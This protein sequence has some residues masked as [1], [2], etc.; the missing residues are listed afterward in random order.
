MLMK[1]PTGW[2]HNYAMGN[3][4]VCLICG[5]KDT[6]HIIVRIRMEE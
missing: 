3:M 6:E 5:E 1:G 2:S 4:N